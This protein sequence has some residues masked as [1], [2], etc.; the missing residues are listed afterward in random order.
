M[1][2][3]WETS[4]A[5]YEHLSSGWRKLRMRLVTEV[6]VNAVNN[7]E[8]SSFGERPGAGAQSG[9]PEALG[10]RGDPKVRDAR[11]GVQWGG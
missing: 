3:D 11:I 7:R 10:G 1:V 9:L 8:Q 5:A 4:K 2:R 6:T